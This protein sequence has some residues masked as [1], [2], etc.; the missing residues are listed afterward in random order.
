MSYNKN[1]PYYYSFYDL[2]TDILSIR[3][4]LYRKQGEPTPPAEDYPWTELLGTQFEIKGSW[5][6]ELRGT[7]KKRDS[8][9]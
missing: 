2:F 4:K 1:L 8:H 9:Q 5:K 3:Q 7:L 6:T